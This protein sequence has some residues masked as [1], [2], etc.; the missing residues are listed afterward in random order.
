MSKFSGLKFQKFDLHVHTPAS[1]DFDDKSVKPKQ[2]V[3]KAI[4][5]GLR[6]IAITD[7]NNGELIDQIKKEAKGTGLIIFPGVEIYC[8]GGE[9]G[10]HI[11]A[12]LSSDKGTKHINGLLA[13]LKINPDDFGTPK[14]VTSFAPYQVIDTIS[15]DP[16]YG[17]AVL[18]HCTSSK[19]VLHDIKG[20][21]RT[22]IFEHKGLLAVETSQNDFTDAEK[23]KKRTRAID[24]LNGKDPNYNQ[25]KLGVYIASDSKKNSEDGHTLDGIGAKF[26]YFKVDDEVDLE[27]LRQC[28]IDREVRIRQQFEFKEN[29]YPYIKSVS[30][31]GSFFNGETAT[32]HQGLNSILGAK[33]SGKSLL[34]ELMRFVFNQVS[35]QK[36]VLDD[37]DRKLQKKLE[38]YGSVNVKFVDE[39]G[40]EH[41]IERVFNPPADN[42]YQEEQHESLASS[43]PILFLSQN[44]IIKIAENENEQI[45]FIDRFFD[46][47]YFQNRIKNIETDLVDLDKQFANGLRAIKHLDEIR[48]QLSKNNAALER[49]NKLLSDTIYDHYKSLEQKDRSLK[50][51][52]NSLRN[53]RDQIN[54]QI[55]MLEKID[56]PIFEEPIKN[57]PAIK[58]NE[59][60][61]KSTRK[62]TVR[63]L[64]EALEI[65]EK[66]ID[67][68]SKEYKKWS[69][70]F[71]D[72][73]KKYEE[74]IRNAGG[75]RK[76]IEV[77]RLRV[78]R[79]IDDLKK[80][81]MIL[82]EQTSNLKN[83]KQE[84]DLLIKKLFSIYG[85]YSL[86]RKNKCQKFELQS[87]SR[88]Q[89]RIHEST[90]VNEFK[91]Q[92]K[93]L[94]KGSYLR[95]AEIEQIC[96]NVSPYDF[97]LNLLRYE[98]SKDKDIKYLQDIATKIGIEIERL[99]SLCDFLISQVP[100][101][102]LL[103]LQ[104]RAHPQ[105]RPEIKFRLNNDTYELI[106]DISVGQK[107]TAMLIMALSDGKFPVIIDQP[108]D[109]LDVRS[110]WDDMCV[111]IR[112]GKEYR[113]FIFT[114][115][116][117]CLAVA[118]DTDKFIIVE[119]SANK[120][121]I[122]FSGALETSAIK[123]EVIKYLEGGRL[124]YEKK[125]LKY[126]I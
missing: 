18:A 105:D 30:V 58:R 124:T 4:E 116:N 102:E 94:K 115:H 81:E 75:D 24:L 38:T 62:E 125:A 54:M 98:A 44:E 45:K 84:R 119:G 21:T 71:L 109:S 9:T 25:K 88:L 37:H 26:T 59:D 114:T 16:Y 93:D 89:V 61:I 82:L 99:Q 13:S 43:F 50:N 68:I 42:P 73:K 15:S 74:H 36:E 85:E 66:A 2:I 11:I 19:G 113:Q 77:Q 39:T 122:V 121:A 97:I 118:S 32:F 76:G 47:Q 23:I 65:T 106:R 5:K 56:F 126:G 108:E 86:E 53:Y 28:F 35:S 91:N 100:Y 17:I 3:E 90:N 55:S 27:S 41:E 83:I 101:E 8:T 20:E 22:K 57:D 10:V 103:Q 110:V 60:V 49:L 1:H 72:E 64:N 87:S 80:R 67:V 107:C 78:I 63:L 69:V 111:K 33:G 120:G 92:L 70:T 48:K 46:F 117:S 95:D 112:T 79:E 104:Y 31:K 51:Q 12:I 123:E 6:G 52:E 96:L 29:I 34:V 7:H 40:M 14:A